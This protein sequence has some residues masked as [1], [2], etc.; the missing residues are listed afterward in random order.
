MYK[1]DV[2]SKTDISSSGS[3]GRADATTFHRQAAK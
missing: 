3:V 2:E 1:I